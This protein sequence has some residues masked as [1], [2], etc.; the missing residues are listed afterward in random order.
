MTKAYNQEN[1]YI[2]EAIDGSGYDTELTTDKE[3]LKFLHDTFNAEYGWE[4][5]RIGQH[6]ALSGWLQ[7]LPS[8]VNIAFYNCDILELAKKW[9]S[10]PADASEK[11]ED[12]ILGNYWNF[13][14]MRIIS[15]WHKHGIA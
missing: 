5:K 3:K 8:S 1:A 12:K 6:K 11:Q 7:G 14:A 4:V 15:L 10:L 9:G 13:M 2:L